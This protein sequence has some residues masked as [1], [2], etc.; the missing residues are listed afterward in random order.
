MQNLTGVKY[1]LEII[2]KYV[3]TEKHTLHKLY[4]LIQANNEK[5]K[6]EAYH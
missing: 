2:Q 6:L 3:T 4:L 1:L 5:M